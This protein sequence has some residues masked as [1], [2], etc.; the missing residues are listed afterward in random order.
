MAVRDEVGE[1]TRREDIIRAAIEVFSRTNYDKATTASIAREAGIAE[2]TT[3]RYFR[4]KK[5][6]FL[7]CYR[8]IVDRLLERYSAIMEE[9]GGDPV[10]Y[11]RAVARS[12]VDFMEENPNVRRF[13][14]F[15]LNNSFD[16]DFRSELESFMLLNVHAVESMVDKAVESGELEEGFDAT[17]AAWLFVGS[18]FTVIVMQELGVE[19]ITRGFADRMIDLVL[20]HPGSLKR[21]AAER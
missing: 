6:L 9:T 15:V 13:L 1:G 10:L 8:Y 4:S 21:T 12:Y 20:K 7:A 11:I 19:E 18:C 2:G 17:A 5:E 3:F 16:E 14:A